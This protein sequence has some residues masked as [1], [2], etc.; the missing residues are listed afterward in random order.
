MV[1]P[2]PKRV[3]NTRGRQKA[4]KISKAQKRTVY[5]WYNN[6]EIEENEIIEKIAQYLERE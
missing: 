1:E 5:H 2:S 3:R 6:I 4:K